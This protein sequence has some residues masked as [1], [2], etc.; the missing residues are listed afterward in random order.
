MNH[1]NLR[2]LATVVNANKN[3][4]VRV[5]VLRGEEEEEEVELELVPREDWGGRGLLGCH[6]VPL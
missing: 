5:R 6:I 4:P 2:G 1:D 3:R